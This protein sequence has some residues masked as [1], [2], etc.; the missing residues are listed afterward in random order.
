METYYNM[1][2][3]AA[4]ISSDLRSH[5]AR[6]AR[7]EIKA[8]DSKGGYASVA[9]R[10]GCEDR[11]SDRFCIPN[12]TL[13]APRKGCEDRNYWRVFDLRLEAGRTPQGVRG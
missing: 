5:P 10:K 12:R 3:S 7:I 4:E 9:P 8:Q 13:V 2:K 1:H 11:N 6:G